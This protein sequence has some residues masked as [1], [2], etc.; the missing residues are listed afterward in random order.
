MIDVGVAPGTTENSRLAVDEIPSALAVIGAGEALGPSRL[1]YIADDVRVAGNVR[2]GEMH[3]VRV[4]WEQGTDGTITQG[5]DDEV[6]R[7]EKLVGDS[8]LHIIG[9]GPLGGPGR[10]IVLWD[11]ARITNDLVVVNDATIQGDASVSGALTVTTDITADNVN[12]ETGDVNV[13]TIGSWGKVKAE[14]AIY[15]AGTFHVWETRGGGPILMR[16]V[17]G[18]GFDLVTPILFE[19]PG[20][21][22]VAP[23]SGLAVAMLTLE[24][25][26][27]CPVV[28]VTPWLPG[29]YDETPGTFPLPLS[30]AAAPPLVANHSMRGLPTGPD[31]AAPAP[32][33]CVQQVEVHFA[34]TSGTP[35]VPVDGE[36]PLDLVFDVKVC[37]C[38]C[39]LT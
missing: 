1:V 9:G 34:T 18:F 5:G 14:N 16:Q 8:R 39:A 20:P 10:D 21:H 35:Y 37:G 3:A 38:Q 36:T 31:G 27:A 7:I 32:D 19:T 23:L 28:V 30:G 24:E 11:D 6:P 13:G 15:A 2:A 25:P 12:V 33:F 26:V 22:T 17:C 29:H 4:R